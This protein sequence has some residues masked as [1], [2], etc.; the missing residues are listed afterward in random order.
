[1]GD[2]HR[3]RPSPEHDQECRPHLRDRRR[4]RGRVRRLSGADRE[5]RRLPSPR[6]PPAGLACPFLFFFRVPMPRI[7]G[8]RPIAAAGGNVI[9]L[10]SFALLCLVVAG[11]SSAGFD[12]CQKLLGR[13]FEPLP[14]VAWLGLASLPLFALPLAW[15]GV[16]AIAPAYWVPA[17]LAAL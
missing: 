6:F 7:A 12:L 9:P 14:M 5:A 10:G 2:P 16:P 15:H 13:H 11:L 8:T 1:Q 3:D 17:L 4:S